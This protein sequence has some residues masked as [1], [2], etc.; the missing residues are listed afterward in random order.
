MKQALQ[1]IIRL[2]VWGLWIYSIIKLGRSCYDELGFFWM[3][4]ILGC[5]GISWFFIYLVNA[6]ESVF[7][8]R[9]D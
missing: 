9:K 5:I 7:E 3:A 6:L 2:V 1:N 4:F 8:N